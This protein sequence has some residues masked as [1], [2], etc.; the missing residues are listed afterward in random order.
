MRNKIEQIN[1]NPVP[2]PTRVNYEKLRAKP[3]DKLIL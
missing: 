2:K 1:K 3:F